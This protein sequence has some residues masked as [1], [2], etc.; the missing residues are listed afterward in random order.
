M[1]LALVAD[2]RMN[3]GPVIVNLRRSPA[4][5][6]NPN[7]ASEA[8]SKATFRK[9]FQAC[10]CRCHRSSSVPKRWDVKSGEP[11]EDG[12]HEDPTSGQL[13]SAIADA[14]RSHNLSGQPATDGSREA[15]GVGIVA[16]LLVLPHVSD[17]GPD[18]EDREQRVPSTRRLRVD[19]RLEAARIDGVETMDLPGSPEGLVQHRFGAPLGRIDDE[20]QL[21]N[22]DFS[23]LREHPLLNS[24][25]AFPPIPQ[26]EVPDDLGHVVDVA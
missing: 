5:T 10:I 9:R 19:G 3:R 17:P 13:P 25:Q 16:H 6:E 15:G 22:Q 1:I 2:L 20:D 11:D 14:V 7:I 26:G 21:R 18:E 24:R 8:P 23:G 12:H 4:A